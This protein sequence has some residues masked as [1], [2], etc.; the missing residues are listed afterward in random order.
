[1]ER[2][3]SDVGDKGTP[4]YRQEG[5]ESFRLKMVVNLWIAKWG[6]VEGGSRILICPMIICL[7]GEGGRSSLDHYKSWPRVGARDLSGF[8]NASPTF[9]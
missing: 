2:K 4:G 9:R 5:Q 8:L 1:V 6:F 7:D 3:I